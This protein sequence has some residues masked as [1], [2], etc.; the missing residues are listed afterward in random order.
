MASAPITI[1]WRVLRDWGHQPEIFVVDDAE[2]VLTEQEGI[3]VHRVRPDVRRIAFRVG[4]KVSRMLG[5]TKITGDL[6]LKLCGAASLAR[7]LHRRER[8]APFDLVQSAEYFGSGLFVRRRHDRPHLVR[9]STAPDLYAEAEQDHS[10]R[11]RLQIRL[12]L[13]AIR[14]ADIAYA[15]SQLVADHMTRVTGRPVGV[16]RPPALQECQAAVEL[17][18]PLPDRYLLHFGQI[19]P[20]KGSAWLAEALPLAWA[21][22]PGLTMVWA[23]GG[24]EQQFSRW[25]S[26]WGAHRGQVTWLGH[27]PKPVIY[28]LLSRAEA[29]VIPSLVDNLPNAVIES[30]IMG[31][32][33]I[34]SNRSSIEELVESGV[35]GELVD[36]ADPHALAAAMVRVWRNQTTA[37]R[38]FEWRSPITQQMRPEVAV[39]NFL[40]LAQKQVIA[41]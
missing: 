3:T 6:L 34:G 22:E 35:T 24:D 31:I 5:L 19:K 11:R 10:Q 27:Q 23:G 4:W 14:R 32:P 33:V 40:A 15:P 2:R 25:S 30:L 21:Q 9:C 17:P 39:R 1:V 8:I 37:R 18:C 13:A 7:A 36:N 26:G 29:A 20:I 41:S 16:V 12:E 28:A 38:G